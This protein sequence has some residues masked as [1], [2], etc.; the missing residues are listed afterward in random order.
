MEN[1][2][3]EIQELIVKHLPSELGETL[4]NLLASAANDAQAL[5]DARAYIKQTGEI[6]A[7]LSA[8]VGELSTQLERHKNID[9]RMRELEESERNR[10]IFQLETELA[11]EKRITSVL[12]QTLGKLVRNTEYRNTLFGKENIP[13]QGTPGSNGYGGTPGWVSTQDVSQTT[14]KTAE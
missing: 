13:V 4:R 2:S 1:L 10:K 3:K 12:D 9:A 5:Q 7:N 11:A 8:Q 6:T 14:T